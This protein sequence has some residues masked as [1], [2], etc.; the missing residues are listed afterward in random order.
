MNKM[1]IKRSTDP[2][3]R[4]YPTFMKIIMQVHINGFLFKNVDMN[5]HKMFIQ[6]I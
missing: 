1:K 2:M 4:K 5:D 3:D 6:L